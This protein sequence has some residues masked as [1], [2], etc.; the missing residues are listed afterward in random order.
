MDEGM[1]S[2]ERGIA[3]V[4]D[5][6]ILTETASRIYAASAMCAPTGTPAYLPPLVKG[7]CA[8][9]PDGI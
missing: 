3:Q 1:A 4:D 5:L 8:L 6:A 9:K 7:R 2:L